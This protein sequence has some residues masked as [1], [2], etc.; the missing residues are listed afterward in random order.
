QWQFVPVGPPLPVTNAL[1]AVAESTVPNAPHVA[2]ESVDLTLDAVKQPP[3]VNHDILRRGI[4][5][6]DFLGSNC[7]CLPPD[8]NAAVSNDFVAETTNLQFRVWN[9]TPGNQV[10]NESLATLFGFPSNGDPYVV[11]DDIADRWYVSAFDSPVR[12]LLLA[13][14]FDGNPVHGF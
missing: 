5:G 13:V 6:I 1:I 8:T 12:G 2:I 3:A 10:I 14:S 9:K 4:D 11:Y 7:S